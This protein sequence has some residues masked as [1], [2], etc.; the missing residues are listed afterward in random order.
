MTEK[1]RNVIHLGRQLPLAEAPCELLA[2]A[3]AREAIPFLLRELPTIVAIGM[4]RYD[5]DDS[6][7]SYP[8]GTPRP[9]SVV[10]PRSAVLENSSFLASNTTL[11][12]GGF[13]FWEEQIEKKEY[14]IDEQSEEFLSDLYGNLAD[15]EGVVIR[16]EVREIFREALDPKAFAN[17]Y[18]DLLSQVWTASG[19]RRIPMLSL[20]SK[21]LETTL[22][23]LREVLR[24]LGEERGVVLQ[25]GNLYYYWGLRFMSDGE[26]REWANDWFFRRVGPWAIRCESGQRIK[27]CFRSGNITRIIQPRVVEVFRA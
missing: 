19:E 13:S 24:K 20:Y 2:G 27:S 3:P 10:Y 7:Y 1:R 4:V 9:D 5:S 6:W 17:Y 15:H 25:E 8:D 12:D 21:E 18:V 23:S 16:P 26:V 14:W 11:I 22:E